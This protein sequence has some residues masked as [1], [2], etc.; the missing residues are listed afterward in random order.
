MTPSYYSVIPASVRYC[1]GC[2]PH[3][4]LLF[5]EISAL[6]NKEG[7]CYASNSYFANLYDVRTESISR[8]ISQ[9][10]ENEHIETVSVS[11]GSANNILQRRI[12]ITT[13][14]PAIKGGGEKDQN[15][16]AKKVNSYYT[17]SKELILHNNNRKF[18]KPTVD[19]V[20]DYVATRQVKIDPEH[21]VNHYDG[22]GWMRGKT[23]MKCWKATV[24]TWEKNQKERKNEKSGSSLR[25]S[26]IVERLT[27]RSWAT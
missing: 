13:I 17:N 18:K 22:V 21:F 25:K 1:E 2:S 7:Y 11:T 24:R 10:R 4:K 16:L 26:D 12:Y 3:A 19:E 27:D 14:D 6:S 23:K 9:L 8:W 15:P 20:A 5:S